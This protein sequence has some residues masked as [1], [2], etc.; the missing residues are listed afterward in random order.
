EAHGATPD[1]AVR[2]VETA[3]ERWIEEAVANRREVP[4]PRSAASHSGRLMLRMPQTLHAE[5]ARAAQLED[6][7]LNQ[8]ITGVLSGAVEWRSGAEHASD[9]SPARWSRTALVANL[10]VL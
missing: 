4:K 1:E 10:V 3:T 8:F 6:V 2:G 7:S 9:E 5:L